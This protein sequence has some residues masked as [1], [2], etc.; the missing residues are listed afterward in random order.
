MLELQVWNVETSRG[1][2]LGTVTTTKDAPIK[3]AQAKALV[4][5][6]SGGRFTIGFKLKVKKAS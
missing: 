5:W 2:F 1:E 4:K 6:N 3:I